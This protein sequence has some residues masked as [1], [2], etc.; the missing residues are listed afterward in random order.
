MRKNFIFFILILINWVFVNA[1]TE[2]I[3][4]KLIFDDNILTHNMSITTDGPFLYTCN[5]GVASKGQI[6]KYTLS[7]YFV[8]SYPIDLDM[9]GLFYNPKDKH[10][11]TNCYDRNIYKI[12]DL[13]TGKYELFKEKLY[14]N[15]QAKL[16]L[17]PNGK[18]LYYFNNGILKVYKFPSCKLIKTITGFDYGKE[19]YNGS[20]AVAIGKKHIFT[21]NAEE[22]MIFVYNLKGEKLKTVYITD[23]DYGYSISY[24]K[25]LVFVSVDGNYEVGHWYGYQIEE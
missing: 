19:S 5:G 20:S 8:E 13:K 17:S 14:E 15:E 1:Q 9:R 24:A 6:N 2:R 22:K 25:G 4:P 10:F 21:W 18:F 3:K 11:Y 12:V 7:G 23:G 16:T